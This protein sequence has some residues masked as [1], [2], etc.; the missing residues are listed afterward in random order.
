MPT[1]TKNVGVNTKLNSQIEGNTLNSNLQ[2]GDINREE[3]ENL[4]L[5]E[6]VQKETTVFRHI[7]VNGDFTFNSGLGQH[8]GQAEQSPKTENL[9]SEAHAITLLFALIGLAIFAIAIGFA[10][11]CCRRRKRKVKKEINHK[12]ELHKEIT[13]SQRELQLIEEFNSLKRKIEN[14]R[15]ET[16]LSK[17]NDNAQDISFSSSS[18]ISEI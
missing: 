13:K 1:I 5:D 3:T 17:K 7:H 11:S 10:V 9:I 18:E 12:I 14:S 15:I 4:N 2:N 6:N 8:G 16:V